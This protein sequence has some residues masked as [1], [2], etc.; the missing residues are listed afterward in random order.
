MD[1]QGERWI[2]FIKLL[3]I[4]NLGRKLKNTVGCYIKLITGHMR[5][6]IGFVCMGVFIFKRYVKAF[7][8]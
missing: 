8:H 3:E 5:V 4:M 2:I 7:N 1:T 6:I